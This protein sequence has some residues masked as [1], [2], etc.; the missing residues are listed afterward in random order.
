MLKEFRLLL[1]MGLVLVV[2]GV[3]EGDDAAKAAAKAEAKAR[4]AKARAAQAEAEAAEARRD[5]RLAQLSSKAGV[6]AEAKAVAVH[7]AKA[8]AQAKAEAAQAAAEAELAKKRAAIAAQKAAA[9]ENTGARTTAVKGGKEKAKEAL[10]AFKKANGEYKSLQGKLNDLRAKVR[11]ATDNAAK[12]KVID[13]YN[14]TI[15]AFSTALERT[16]RATIDVYRLEPG[17]H[18]EVEGFMLSA[19]AVLSQLDDYEAALDG[20]KLMLKR[21]DVDKRLHGFAGVAAFMVNDYAMAEKQFALAKKHQAMDRTA[22]RF[23]GQVKEYKKFWKRELE[24]RAK[25]AKA[26]DLP[27]VK[28]VTTAGTMV[29]E[30]YEN[31]APNTVANFVSLVEKKYYD[32]L[33]FHRVL[34]GFMAQGGCPDGTGRGG[35]GYKIACEC[36]VPGYRQHFRGTLSMAHAGRNTG[37]SQFFLTFVPTRHLDGKH[38]AFGRVIK[39]LDVLAKIRKRDPGRGGPSTKIK[40]ATVVRKRNHK[41][42]P[43]KQ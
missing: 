39:G 43:V 12:N 8:A 37:G 2:G 42:E 17:K 41:Y 22:M 21:G 28:M 9:P 25:E 19:V 15:P 7:K 27:R 26:N 24:I 11:A 20:A 4:A 10:A 14:A 3:V 34:T 33:I 36:Y 32:G 23:A 5:E 38:T 30:L 40:K 35:P 16:A 29:I 18:K 13:E 6:A 1:V 31:E